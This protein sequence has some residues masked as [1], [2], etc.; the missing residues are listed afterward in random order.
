MLALLANVM[1]IS[2]AIVASVFWFLSARKEP[3]ATYGYGT[4]APD[5]WETN[6]SPALLWAKDNAKKSRY[7]A[8][9]S[10]VS[11]MFFALATTLDLIGKA[12]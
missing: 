10:G 1:A 11:A 9:A 7:A 2:A 12:S 6:P 3:P 5:D 8:I 4:Y